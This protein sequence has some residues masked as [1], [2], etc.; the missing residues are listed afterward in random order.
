VYIRCTLVDASEPGPS[1]VNEVAVDSD[2][3][4]GIPSPFGTQYADPVTLVVLYTVDLPLIVRN[5]PP[6]L[7]TPELDAINNPDGDGAYTVRWSAVAG[8]TEYVLQEAKRSDFSDAAQVYRGGNTARTISGRGPT[9]YYYRVRAQS[10]AAVSNWSNTEQVDVVWELEP[11]DDALTQANG[12]IVSGVTYYGTFP[13]RQTDW[14]DYYYFDLPIQGLVELWLTDIPAGQDFDLVLRD[15]ALAEIARSDQI[16][17]PSEHIQKSVEAGRYYV[18][19]VHW[20]GAGS[21]QAYRL[22]AEYE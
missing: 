21:T 17:T 9:R 14:K 20:A 22:K 13:N 18:Q 16:G 12:P 4:P 10:S 7:G 11:N 15:A 5:F 19:V 3:E 6:D 8:A 2:E 1:I